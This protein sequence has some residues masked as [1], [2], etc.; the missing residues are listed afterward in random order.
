ME[1]TITPAYS[2]VI[3]DWYKWNI[4]LWQDS[5]IV[6]L[7][8]DSK[9]STSMN[10]GFQYR[11]PAWQWDALDPT[12]ITNF[13]L[14][15]FNELANI[16][17][18]LSKETLAL[19]LSISNIVIRA[20]SARWTIENTKNLLDIKSSLE[21]DTFF[22][23]EVKRKKDKKYQRFLLYKRFIEQFLSN[24]EDFTFDID[25]VNMEIIVR[26]KVSIQ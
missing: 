8:K 2:T 15:R 17:L 4:L 11:L 21:V 5:Y 13:W 23:Q 6:S 25:T 16:I 19:E 12:V 20:E 10:L 3:L 7:L 1:N 9:N 22:Y 14:W 24:D 26:R 18:W